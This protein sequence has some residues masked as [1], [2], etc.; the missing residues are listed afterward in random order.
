MPLN[1]GRIYVTE[2]QIICGSRDG[3]A[4]VLYP[5]STYTTESQI[6]CGSRD[7]TANVLYP[8]STYT[9]PV[10]Q[11][12][13]NVN[14]ATLNGYTYSQ[15]ISAISGSSLKM[16]TGDY[17]Q[18][19][20]NAYAELLGT[21]TIDFSSAGFTRRPFVIANARGY[22]SNTALGTSVNVSTNATSTTSG[23]ISIHR[24]ASSTSSVD[25]IWLAIGI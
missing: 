18:S 15:I 1:S 11:Q 7:G 8:H 5:H 24:T 16:A 23:T 22:N 12:C 6:I 3:T 19:F 21:M 4:N 13:S 20:E 14:A 10:M 9:H 2:S 25:V 17:H